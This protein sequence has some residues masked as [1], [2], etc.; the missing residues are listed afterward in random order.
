[1]ICCLDEVCPASTVP[2]VAIARVLAIVAFLSIA[3]GGDLASAGL[4]LDD[5]DTVACLGRAREAE[6]LYRRIL[7]ARTALLGHSE[8]RLQPIRDE[9]VPEFFRRANALRSGVP[10]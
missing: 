1:M 7:A 3:V 10:L 9:F 4:A 6:D 5:A 8:D 2:P